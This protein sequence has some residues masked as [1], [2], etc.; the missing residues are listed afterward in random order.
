MRNVV[1]SFDLAGLSGSANKNNLNISKF[2]ASLSPYRDYG[3]D[4]NK[5][6]PSFNSEVDDFNN[7]PLV[8]F[9]LA[10]LLDEVDDGSFGDNE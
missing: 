7:D 10:R 4:T 5:P 2:F 3:D 9:L 6:P 1:I 8:D